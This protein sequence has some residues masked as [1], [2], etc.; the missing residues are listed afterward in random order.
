MKSIPNVVLFYGPSGVGK[1]AIGRAASEDAASKLRA[2]SMSMNEERDLEWIK[3]R[4]VEA[5]KD[6]Q[7]RKVHTTIQLNEFDDFLSNKPELLDEFL[8]II[9]N[10][11]QRYHTTFFI[12]TNNPRMINDAV[13]KSADII[14]PMGPASKQDAMDIAKF[15]VGQKN[16]QGLNWDKI[17]DKL[18]SYKPNF[19]YSNAQIETIFSSL[20]DNASMDDIMQILNDVKPIIS[21][22]IMDKFA[23]EQAELGVRVL[24]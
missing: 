11:V 18:D 16:I 22:E 8:D 15:Y 6:Y 20:Q 1:T 5:E 23:E 12:T 9:K 21:K 24:R 13:L 2:R 7:T 3:K 14:L 19:A 17:A 4:L 10:S